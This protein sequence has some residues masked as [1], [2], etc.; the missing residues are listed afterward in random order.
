MSK[1]A[2]YHRLLDWA[3]QWPQR[4][5]AVE[6]A[7]GLGHHLA[8]WLLLAG[9]QVVDVPSTA[10]AK[11][12]A[13][14]RGGRRKNDRID[15]AA[16]A[17]VAAIHGECQP[18]RAEGSAD[19]L[20]LLDERRHTLNQHRTRY[21]NQLHAL[22]RE[23]TPG[24]APRSLSARRASRILPTIRPVSTTDQVRLQLA[25]QLVCDIER[26]DHDLAENTKQMK[27]I[28]GT[29][30]T[31]LTS[32]VGVG[33]VLASRI[34]AGTRDPLRFTT[35]AAFANYTGT[36]PVQVASGGYNRHRLSRYGN[37]QLN[38]ALHSVA[39]IQIRTKSS[40]GRTYYDKKL[41][42]GK[43]PREA[44]RCLKRQIATRVWKTM[45]KDQPTP[46]TTTG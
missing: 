8:Q 35:A 37:R 29:Q 46:T 13:L 22:L 41:A 45:I 9:E 4:R 34:L 12:R 31:T 38:S 25:E 3:N 17:C 27:T 39:I 32:L 26:L 28:L 15:A 5:W 16:A 2:D 43:T 20:A 7:D 14:S 24:G 30:N 21:L 6:N 40:S 23:L 36:A 11:V 18:V 42:E 19:A 1:A 10:T 33:P 44:I